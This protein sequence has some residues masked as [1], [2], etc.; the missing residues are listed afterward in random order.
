MIDYKED[1]LFS[2][3][4]KREGSVALRAAIFGF[5]AAIVASLLVCMD[6][7]DAA[8]QVKEHTSLMSIGKSQIWAVSTGAIVLLIGFRTKQAFSRF[9][10]GTG[11]LHQMRGEWFDTVSNCISFSIAAKGTRAAEVEAFRHTIVR[12]MSLCHGCAL[13]EIAGYT[14]QL[15]CID[16]FGLNDETL[17]H[18][19]D[20]H[21]NWGFNKVEVMVHLLQS[22][23]TKAL[24]DG[25]LQVPPPI[26]S[27]VYQT[28]SRGFVNLLNAK[29]I[30]VTKF[31]FPY[32]NLIATL[33]FF[34]LLLTP[35]QVAVAVESKVLAGI[36]TFIP[37]WSLFA[38]NF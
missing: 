7:W 37:V 16:T 32:A 30:T 31:P 22:L 12:I 2:L 8:A 25:I 28:I 11:L 14:C 33:L 18:L 24:D 35:L 38:L 29:K 15:K 4:C 19:N 21:D 27:R 23:I 3:I 13:E 9:W 20:C 6:E 1:W 26:L 17:H 5:P 36:F 34:H 10:E